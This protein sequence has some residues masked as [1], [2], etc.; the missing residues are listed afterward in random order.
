[1]IK[2]TLIRGLYGYQNKATVRQ[3]TQTFRCWKSGQICM[4]TRMCGEGEAR[5]RRRISKMIFGSVLAE[6]C[7]STLI[8]E[9]SKMRGE[10]RRGRAEIWTC[11]VDRRK[12]HADSPGF[13]NGDH[14][15]MHTPHNHHHVWFW[16]PDCL[17]FAPFQ[18]AH[19]N[20]ISTVLL[21]AKNSVS[22]AMLPVYHQYYG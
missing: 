9:Q 1:M 16:L 19:T 17:R 4:R 8:K 14:H 7:L 13:R 12:R 2:D 18:T 5:W 6:S 15:V 20:L 22:L 10:H 21:D 11:H 3:D